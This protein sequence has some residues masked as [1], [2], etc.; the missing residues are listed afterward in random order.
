MPDF[1]HKIRHDSGAAFL[2]NKD[3][4]GIDKLGK[5]LFPL[6]CWPAWEVNLEQYWDRDNLF[7]SQS[8]KE[9]KADIGRDR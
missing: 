1:S 5:F 6:T 8:G 3:L 9:E 2:A 4:R 7:S